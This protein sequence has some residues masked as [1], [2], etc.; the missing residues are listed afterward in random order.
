V[1]RAGVARDYP[2]EKWFYDFDGGAYTVIIFSG[3]TIINIETSRK[4]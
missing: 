3:D 2:V 4:W 1:L